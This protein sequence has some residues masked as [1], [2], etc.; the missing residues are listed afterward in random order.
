MI[1]TH[2]PAPWT[3]L[4]YNENTL[5]AEIM[6]GDV[7]LARIPHWP[8]AN[9]E[10]QANALLISGA[11]DLLEALEGARIALTAYKNWMSLQTDGK[12]DFPFGITAEEKAREAIRKAKGETL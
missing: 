11:P 4:T 2:T 1:N 7:C 8:L 10:S 6:S 5:H 3:T 9:D 12:T